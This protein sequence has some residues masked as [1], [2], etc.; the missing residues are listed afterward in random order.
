MKDTCGPSMVSSLFKG[1]PCEP[2]LFIDFWT[3]DSILLV[4]TSLLKRNCKARKLQ[5]NKV[6]PKGWIPTVLCSESEASSFFRGL[7]G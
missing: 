3:R 4:V 1:E 6:L 7:T 2:R 5:W